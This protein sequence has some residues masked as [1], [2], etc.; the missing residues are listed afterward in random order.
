MLSMAETTG[1]SY[2]KLAEIKTK[3]STVKGIYN[4]ICQAFGE[5]FFSLEEI[6]HAMKNGFIDV[7]TD[8][9]IIWAD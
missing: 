6:E 4:A 5:E 1:G 2:K 8:G 9:V 3:A 7:C